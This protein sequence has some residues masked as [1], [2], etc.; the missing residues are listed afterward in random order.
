MIY[1]EDLDVKGITRNHSLARAADTAMKGFIRQAKYKAEW[2]DRKF[3]KI[4]RFELSSK[5]C[6]TCKTINK[7]LKL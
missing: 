6:S 5:M 2:K 7:E 1:A 3:V 4:G